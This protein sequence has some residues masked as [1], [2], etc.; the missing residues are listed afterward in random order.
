[1]YFLQSFYVFDLF[2]TTVNAHEYTKA[3]INKIQII[4]QKY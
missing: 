3:N 1:M 2:Y 4:Q